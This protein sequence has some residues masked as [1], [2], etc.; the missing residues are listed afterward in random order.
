MS[1]DQAFEEAFKSKSQRKREMEALRDLV[2]QM[3][4]SRQVVVDKLLVSTRIKEEILEA[5]TLKKE[6]LRRQIHHIANLLVHENEEELRRVVTEMHQPHREQT[7]AFHALESWRERLLAGDDELL[8]Q[9]VNE[10]EQADRQRLRQLIRNANNEAKSG[11][12]PKSSRAL[13]KILRE[14][15]EG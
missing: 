3:I 2:R 12:P 14:L 1:E 10:Y 4:D 9:I 11:K 5:R 13:F 7:K 15:K 8:N 6:A